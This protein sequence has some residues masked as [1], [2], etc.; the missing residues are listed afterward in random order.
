MN[1]KIITFLHAYKFKNSETFICKKIEEYVTRFDQYNIKFILTK[2][3]LYINGSVIPFKVSYR[4]EGDGFIPQ[5]CIDEKYK[6]FVTSDFEDI[7]TFSNVVFTDLMLF[8]NPHFNINCVIKYKKDFGRK[9]NGKTE[10]DPFAIVLSDCLIIGHI[11]HEFDGRGNE[12][13]IKYE[14]I[15][16]MLQMRGLFQEDGINYIPSFHYSDV[17]AKSAL[18]ICASKNNVKQEHSGTFLGEDFVRYSSC[19]ILDK[20]CNDYQF[21]LKKVYQSQKIQNN[22]SD[23]SISKDF[24]YYASEICGI[25]LLKKRSDDV[26]NIYGTSLLLESFKVYIYASLYHIIASAEDI[27]KITIKCFQVKQLIISNR[28]TWWGLKLKEAIEDHSLYQNLT[29][30]IDLK[31]HALTFEFDKKEFEL[32]Q[33]KEK[34]QNILNFLMCILAYL[35]GISCIGL[36][37]ES[38]NQFQIWLFGTITALFL[39]GICMIYHYVKNSGH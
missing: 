25:V 38:L 1:N 29:E 11:Y 27:D 36:F 34:S 9:N 15:D 30:T 4:Q 14:H 17:F 8:E 7:T 23:I 18:E 33:R 32:A 5:F 13:E 2:D 10:H 22:L 24:Q 21:I 35:S 12:I 31:R 28:S 39:I 20:T 6:D 37:G 16:H 19:L 3:K 26:K